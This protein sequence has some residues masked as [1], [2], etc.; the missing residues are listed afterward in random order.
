MRREGGHVPTPTGLASVRGRWP[1]PA[2][3]AFSLLPSHDPSEAGRPAS[4][5]PEHPGLSPLGRRALVGKPPTR[6]ESL[7]AACLVW[8]LG[9]TPRHPILITWGAGKTPEPGAPSPPPMAQASWGAPCT[10]GSGPHLR[11]GRGCQGR[12]GLHARRWGCQSPGSQ[13]RHL[14]TRLEIR[15]GQK[16]REASGEQPG[17]ATSRPLPHHRECHRQPRPTL[18]G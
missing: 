16:Q 12:A 9:V 14:K 13:W 3:S 6:T 2:I 1:M 8:G 7:E 11:K 5:E 10:S 18:Q 17:P 4:P 15:M